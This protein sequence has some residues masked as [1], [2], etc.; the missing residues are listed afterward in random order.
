MMNSQRVV[1][2]IDNN[3]HDLQ[4]TAQ[5]LKAAG[6]KVLCAA[7]GSHGLELFAAHRMDL[8]I[9]E[10]QMTGRNGECVAAVMRKAQPDMPILLYSGHA[11]VSKSTLDLMNGFMPKGTLPF[12]LLR[13]VRVLFRARPARPGAGIQP[14]ER[15]LA[16]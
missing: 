7:S 3:A 16:S 1:L 12:L 11:P 13:A 8:V 5:V 15:R 10:H 14:H 6:Y 2:L 4:R 9:L